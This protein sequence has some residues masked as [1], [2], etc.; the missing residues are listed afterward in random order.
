[1]FAFFAK[2]PFLRLSRVCEQTGIV[3]LFLIYV[4]LKSDDM[5]V[6][7]SVVHA[8]F[9]DFQLYTVLKSLH[10]MILK[11]LHLNRYEY[12]QLFEL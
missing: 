8:L 4:V 1:M 10:R 7:Y 11:L 6:N 9:Y 12:S 2:Y 5:I 3:K